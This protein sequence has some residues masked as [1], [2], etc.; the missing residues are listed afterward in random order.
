ME[1][2]LFGTGASATPP[3]PSPHALGA[4]TRA[5]LSPAQ[6]AL[7]DALPRRDLAGVRTLL[8]EHAGHAGRDGALVLDAELVVLLDSTSTNPVFVVGG[9][10]FDRD[11]LAAAFPLGAFAVAPEHLFARQRVG[12]V[13]G[14]LAAWDAPDAPDG[15][16]GAPGGAPAGAAGG[17]PGGAPAGVDTRVYVA[18]DAF[19]D[20][21]AVAAAARG[22]ARVAAAGGSALLACGGSA[23]LA[24]AGA[25]E[26]DRAS[27][28]HVTAGSASLEARIAALEARIAALEWSA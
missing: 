19:A 15:P 5:L 6:R 14:A 17:A 18:R 13:A 23:L 26:D 3:P 9:D 7:L 11:S 24:L 21:R 1:I 20:F 4:G 25:R 22:A 2:Q 12:Y 10:L 16:D 27:G 8:A 28:A